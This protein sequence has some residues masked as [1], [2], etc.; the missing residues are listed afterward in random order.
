VPRSFSREREKTVHPCCFIRWSIPL[1]LSPFAFAVVDSLRAA[2][3]APSTTAAE[4][5]ATKVYTSGK[6]LLADL[7]KEAFPKTAPDAGIE[8]ARALRWCKTHLLG[9]TVE[10]TGTITHV[11]VDEVIGD[12]E[13]LFDVRLK[14]DI[15]VAK[16]S[17]QGGAYPVLGD[18]FLLGDQR[19]GVVLTGSAISH[20][21]RDDERLRRATFV[22]TIIL[23]NCSESEAIKLRELN[24]KMV[25]LRSLIT[26]V[27]QGGDG[28]AFQPDVRGD[29]PE[30]WFGFQLKVSIPSVN[31]LTT[32]YAAKET[33]RAES[34]RAKGGGSPSGSRS[35]SS[36]SAR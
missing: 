10:W 20:T 22:S 34:S 11:T 25:T 1:L 30:E 35:S 13:D 29:K 24:G 31:G 5:S 28:F 17:G 16:K 36:G 4:T 6:D 23:R 8:R 15:P 32:K 21:F 27:E 7:P 33:E 18:T 2:D 3:P 19:C 12:T 26:G 9:K 14:T